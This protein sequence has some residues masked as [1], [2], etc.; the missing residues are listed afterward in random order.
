[1]ERKS[2][3]TIL[4]VVLILW[5]AYLFFTPHSKI[6]SV[7]DFESCV[8]V[9][10]PVMESY[11]R[12]CRDPKTDIT[13]VEVVEDYW[14]FDGIQLMQNETDGIY[15]CFGCSI[16]TDDKPGLC[17][18][19]ANVMKE[20]VETEDR[21][22]SSDFEVIGVNTSVSCLPEQRNVDLCNDIYQPVCATVNVQCITTPCNPV[23]Q[24][25]ENSCKACDDSLVSD[26]IEGECEG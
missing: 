11:P 25:F 15:W 24:T 22:C 4:I 6:N 12:Q 10:N 21:Y 20:A 18:D 16:A 26:Y 17:V 19:P 5:V 2:V 23:N 13:F 9:G 8:D 3:I 14:R 7:T 1:M